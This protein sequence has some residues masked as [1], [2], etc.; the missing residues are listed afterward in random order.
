MAKHLELSSYSGTGIRW[1]IGDG[2][3]INIRHDPWLRDPTIFYIETNLDEAQQVT[4]VSDLID[5]SL[6]Q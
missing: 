6:H 3:S 1:K 2:Q 4:M 5:T